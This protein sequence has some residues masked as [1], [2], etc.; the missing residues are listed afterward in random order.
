MSEENT[1]NFSIN[2]KVEIIDGESTYKTIVQDL[3][4][5]TISIGVPV[6]EFRSYPIHM[7]EDLEYFIISKGDIYRCKSNIIGRKTENNVQMVI[8]N[9]PEICVRVQRREYFRLNILMDIKYYPLSNRT[10]STIKDVSKGYLNKM[11][12]STALD[13]SGG[14]IRIICYEKIPKGSYVLVSFNIPE[15]IVVLCNVVW[16]QL[17]NTDKNYKA[18]L[19]YVNIDERVRD[20]VIRF[21]FKKTREQS[22]L[23]R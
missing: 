12:S 11:K 13:I 17:D 19:K 23:I 22:K 3:D 1:M 21:I 9:K 15:E 5:D 16:C 4:R 14:G 18:A 8:L 6:F 10:Y 20:K 7:G 2:D